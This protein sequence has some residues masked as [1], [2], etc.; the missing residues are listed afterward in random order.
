MR[1]FDAGA[2]AAQGLQ[3][4]W[5]QHGEALNLRAGTLRGLHF[6]R[7]PHAEIKVIRCTRGRAYDVV[8][9][10]RRE[11]PTYGRWEAFV[12]AEDDA[13][14]LYVPAGFAHGYQTLEARTTMHYLHSVPYAAD[15]A[16]GYRYDSPQ[17]AIAWPSP[18]AVISERDRGLPPFAGSRTDP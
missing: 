15:A 13:T 5:P 12:L 17:L 10:V 4:A 3:T 2:F 1:T 9:D 7:A 16:A 8:V 6:Q 14:A 18:A 11:S